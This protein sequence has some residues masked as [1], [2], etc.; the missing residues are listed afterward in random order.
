MGLVFF[1]FSSHEFFIIL[2]FFFKL[3]DLNFDL[4]DFLQDLFTFFLLLLRPHH[5]LFKFVLSAH[6]CFKVERFSHNWVF[7]V[8]LVDENCSSY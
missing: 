5:E 3:L 2:F 6:F 7:F 1:Y 4:F 8:A